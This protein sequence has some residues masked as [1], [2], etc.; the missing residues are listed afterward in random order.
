MKIFS[1]QAQN[2]QSK[3]KLNRGLETLTLAE[4]NLERSLHQSVNT[5]AQ[6]LV[7]L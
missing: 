3:T 4:K 5:I 1:I 6:S 7:S 2:F